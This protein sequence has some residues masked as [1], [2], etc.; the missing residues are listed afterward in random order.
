M[1]DKQIIPEI[2]KLLSLEDSLPDF[3]LIRFQLLKTG[4]NLDLCR[5]ETESE[6][7]SLLH[8]TATISSWQITIYPHLMPSG[9][10]ICVIKSVRALL[11]ICV[12]G[13][14]GEDKAIELMKTGR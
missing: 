14:I 5:I 12:S 1:K 10:C 3:E 11:F 9:L 2:L 7:V 13:Y 6:F 4:Y 8:Q